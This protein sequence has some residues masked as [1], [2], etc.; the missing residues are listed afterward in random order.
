MRPGSGR[1]ATNRSTTQLLHGR[2][3]LRRLA[4]T[5][6]EQLETECVAQ[7]LVDGVAA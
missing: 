4:T 6:R 7:Y 5:G 3:E 2:D 1:F